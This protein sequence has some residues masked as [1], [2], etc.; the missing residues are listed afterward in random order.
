MAERAVASAVLLLDSPAISSSNSTFLF[1]LPVRLSTRSFSLLSL[2]SPVTSSRRSLPRAMS[3]YHDEQQHTSP[4]D[5]QARRQAIVP[6]SEQ[7]TSPQQYDEP[8]EYEAAPPYDLYDE[9]RASGDG[10]NNSELSHTSPAARPDP[11]AHRD[12]NL[13][14]GSKSPA[15]APPK[16][17]CSR[18]QYSD[19]RR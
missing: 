6:N 10:Q 12:L 1:L 5:R 7:W 17:V 13:L 16:S 8:S 2:I 18:H 14:A 19:A 11:R 4:T 15:H 3:Q 9:Q